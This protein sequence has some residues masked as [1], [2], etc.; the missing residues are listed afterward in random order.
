MNNAITHDPISR[1][2]FL[3]LAAGTAAGAMLFKFPFTAS[4][5]EAAAAM[6]IHPIAL[7]DLPKTGEAAAK[8]APLIKS[9]YAD[10]LKIVD[11]I[12]DSSLRS[13]V[14]AMIKNPFPTFMENYTSS[15]SIQ[16]LYNQLLDQKLID[17]SKISAE[18]LLPPVPTKLQPFMTAPGSGYM[19]HHSYPGGLS[20]HVDSNLHITVGICETY[21]DVFHY[22]V[23]YDTAVAAQALHDIEKPFVFQWQEDGSSRKEYTIA[24][25]GA[26]HVLSIAESIY[27]GMPAEEIVA[28]ACAHAAPTS[29]KRKPMSSA[30]SARPPSSSAKTLSASVSSPLTAKA[31]QPRTSRK[32]TSST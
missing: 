7:V 26:H 5:K 14:L 18:T 24:G 4:A 23:D 25:Q 11:T 30:G 22:D 3:K 15:S 21:K 32:A 1:R 13:A 6:E 12:K 2:T 29:K 17:P 8:A 16:R 31:S 9:S 10:I 19:S 27:R 20:T 28:Q